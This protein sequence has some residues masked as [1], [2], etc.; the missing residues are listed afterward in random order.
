MKKR[1][2][3]E[4]EKR[5]ID[6]RGGERKKNRKKWEGGRTIKRAK[7]GKQTERE[8]ERRKRKSKIYFMKRVKMFFMYNL[9]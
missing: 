6:A 3:S 8:R 1:R 9:T 7:E 2:K 4:K 5:K